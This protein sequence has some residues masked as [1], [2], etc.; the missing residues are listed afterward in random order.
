MLFFELKCPVGQNGENDA[1]DF[2]TLVTVTRFRLAGDSV[3]AIFDAV[4]RIRDYTLIP[5]NNEDA[6]SGLGAGRFHV[7]PFLAELVG[8]EALDAL[9]MSLTLDSQDAAK[10]VAA[11]IIN[12]LRDIAFSMYIHSEYES[13]KMALGY[14]GETTVVIATDP[15]IR[16]YLQLD[17]ELR[18]LSEKFNVKVVDTLDKRFRGKIFMTFVVMDGSRNEVPNILNWGNLIWAPEVVHHASVPRG[19]SM[20]RETI[21]QPR[22]RFVNHLPIATLLTFNNVPN[23][24]RKL[25]INFHEVP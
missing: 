4:D 10:N 3:T 14:T 9:A 24:L 1:A 21:V 2:E 19:E 7:K 16:R 15:Y 11:A 20:S 6:P 17:G 5:F 8:A 13:A 18:T 23:V 22:Y 12:K 25:N